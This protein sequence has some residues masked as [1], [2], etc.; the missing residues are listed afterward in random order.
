MNAEKL[1]KLQAQVRIG[2][3]GTPRRKKKVSESTCPTQPPT[4]SSASLARSLRV[5]RS[6]DRSREC[7][8]PCHRFPRDGGGAPFSGSERC[9]CD[10]VRGFYF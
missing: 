10:T 9:A 2:G 1:K 8:H 5:R 6:G 7:I 4:Y 3:K